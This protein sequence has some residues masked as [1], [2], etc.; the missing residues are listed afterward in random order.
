MIGVRMLSAVV[1]AAA[2]SGCSVIPSATSWERVSGDYQASG[3][4]GDARAYAYGGATV[5]ELPG[6]HLF[7]GVYDDAGRSLSYERM[8]S[9]YYR[10]PAQLASFTVRANL[11]AIRF[12]LAPS[13]KAMQVLSAEQPT[14][15]Q[16]GE[17][18][19]GADADSRSALNA[20][21]AAQRAALAG[22]VPADFSGNT[23]IV[24]YERMQTSFAV[25]KE[26]ASVIEGA[27]KSAT[28]IHISGWTDSKV[29]G[30]RDAEIAH[31][32]AQA[33]AQYLID[34]GVAKEK[35]QVSHQAAGGFLAAGQGPQARAIN[36]RVELRFSFSKPVGGQPA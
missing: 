15:R 12:E 23:L 24:G 25:R 16:S 18:R 21:I 10:L 17:T 11:R 34:H 32:R 13:A 29:A 19:E 7:L 35:I 28:A 30:P 22:L 5:L 3:D 1:V 33:A 9:A 2:L 36:R 20:A 27:A 6:T 31:A 8:G 26:L 14:L 4:I